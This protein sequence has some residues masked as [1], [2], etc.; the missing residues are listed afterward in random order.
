MICNQ[1]E[2]TPLDLDDAILLAQELLTGANIDVKDLAQIDRR[3]SR[4]RT[5]LYSSYCR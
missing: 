3:V 2:V 5:I 4:S 1:E